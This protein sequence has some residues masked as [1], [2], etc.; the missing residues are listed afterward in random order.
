MAPKS[1]QKTHAKAKNR[2]RGREHT[3]QTVRQKNI[4]KR[5]SENSPNKAPKIGKTRPR[6]WPQKSQKRVKKDPET[7]KRTD[8]EAAK[9][10]PKSVSRRNKRAC[11]KRH[12]HS[13][14]NGRPQTIRE[15]RITP[16]YD[17]MSSMSPWEGHRKKSKNQTHSIQH[18][19]RSPIQAR[20]T[21]RLQPS[22]QSLTWLVVLTLIHKVV[23]EQ[24]SH[25]YSTKKR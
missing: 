25:Y 22:S 7:A 19:K 6:K 10:P 24:H 15:S 4:K 13:E 23:C 21:T 17:K 18:Q 9:T 8:R 3:T 14:L 2:Q 20:C 11:D 5:D 12:E 16:G 1:P